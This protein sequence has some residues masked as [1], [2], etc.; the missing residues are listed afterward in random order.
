MRV[1]RAIL[2]AGAAA[3][4]FTVAV[5]IQEFAVRLV[6]PAY[7]PSGHL[8]FE[9]SGGV[10][11][12]PRNTVQH[13]VKNSGDYDVTVRFNRYGL[14][15][16]PD[17]SGA[18]EADYFVVGDSFGLPPSIAGRREMPW[19]WKQRCSEERVRCGMVA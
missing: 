10:T 13:L 1:A 2:T 19:R 8:R 17:L 9:T 12:G 15:D 3:G 11:L 16:S 6:L 7:D 5:F 4:A 18:T 14:R